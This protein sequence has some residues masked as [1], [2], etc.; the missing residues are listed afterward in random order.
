M[1][2]SRKKRIHPGGMV[3]KIYNDGFQRQGCGY[4][5]QLCHSWD[6]ASALQELQTRWWLLGEPRT[7]MTVGGCHSCEE[8][9]WWSAGWWKLKPRFASFLESLGNTCTIKRDEA[10]M[11]FGGS[12]AQCSECL[13][14]V[15]MFWGQWPCDNSFAYVWSWFVLVNPET[16]E[17][18]PLV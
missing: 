11:C 5:R 16:L 9:R 7:V 14:V 6:E 17:P 18:E 10:V 3:T 1:L 12:C 4:A 2:G 15:L 13:T 8:E